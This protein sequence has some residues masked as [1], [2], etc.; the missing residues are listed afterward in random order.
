MQITLRRD[1]FGRVIGTIAEKGSKATVTGA[2]RVAAI[3]ELREAVDS[4]LD[5]SIGECFWREPLGDYRWL[6]RREG[7][8]MRVVVLKSAGTLT[9]WEHC[10]WAECDAREFGESMR[11]AIEAYDAGELR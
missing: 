6:F 2:D 8:A 10:F 4:A 11:A 5:H 3:A 9:G 7:G 1:E